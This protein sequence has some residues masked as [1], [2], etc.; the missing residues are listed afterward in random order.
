MVKAKMDV[1]GA[2]QRHHAAPKTFGAHL[3]VTMDKA[4]RRLS[5]E[6]HHSGGL[7]SRITTKSPPPALDAV[8]CDK[9]DDDDEEDEEEDDNDNNSE[10]LV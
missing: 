5:T 7:L 10:G 3:K 4:K 1:S 9:Y 2:L 6:L 8:D